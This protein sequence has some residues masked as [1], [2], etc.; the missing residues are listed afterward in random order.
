MIL[1]F[2]LLL[3]LA[4]SVF[5]TPVV[6]AAAKK[7]C[8]EALELP[9]NFADPNYVR[10]HMEIFD[11]LSKSVKSSLVRKR[12]KLLLSDATRPLSRQ[13]LISVLGELTPA[14]TEKDLQNVLRKH[15]VNRVSRSQIARRLAGLADPE[16]AA[17]EQA[18]GYKT[19]KDMQ[20]LVYGQDPLNP[21]KESLIG[22]YLAESKAGHIQRRFPRGPKARE[23]IGEP[24]L[25]VALETSKRD[26]FLKYFDFPELLMHYHTPGQETLLIYFNKS[27]ISYAGQNVKEQSPTSF[28]NPGML[29]PIILLDTS[30]AERLSNYLQL[31]Q[32]G[33][34]A[35]VPWE[36]PNYC[37]MGGYNSCTHWFGEMPIGEKRVDAYSFPGKVDEHAYSNSEMSKRPQ[38]SALQKYWKSS[39]YRLMLSYFRPQG[40]IYP[41]EA[42]DPGLN[43]V[44]RSIDFAKY[45]D[46]LT[47]Q[48]WQVP[49][50]LPF[51]DLLGQ[52][53]A[54]L[55]G[56]FA[57]PGYVA[58]VLLGRVNNERVPVV[59]RVQYVSELD[60]NFD[61]EI[62]AY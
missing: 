19:L 20:T 54:K 12:V 23:G 37:A 4:S 59:F 1:R 61:L 28:T 24:K 46:K 42:I 47:R 21:S 52:E 38:I 2:A 11:A 17:L 16:L 9:R 49:G 62:E 15:L 8:Q 36:L 5:L 27:K 3:S 25:T 57:N 39:N 51:A 56:E 43:N 6:N 55:R 45:V 18:L 13:K 58:D 30:E 10:E 53:A 60:P 40:G 22:R 34:K 14:S 50:R 48:V 29:L 44:R 35:K 32:L 7:S 26:L 31:E 41:G 33:G